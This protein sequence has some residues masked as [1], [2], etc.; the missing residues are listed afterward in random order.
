M[1]NNVKVGTL[2][3]IVPTLL[4]CQYLEGGRNRALYRSD[5]QITKSHSFSLKLH[6]WF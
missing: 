6:S 5:S 4:S 1:S 2:G 3:Y